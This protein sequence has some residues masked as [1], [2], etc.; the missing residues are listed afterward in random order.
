MKVK[1]QLNQAL[2]DNAITI[3]KKDLYKKIDSL[4]EDLKKENDEL[5]SSLDTKI[6]KTGLLDLSLENIEMSTEGLD[7]HNYKFPSIIKIGNLKT[8]LSMPSKIISGEQ[9]SSNIPFYIPIGANGI[10]V[11]ENQKFKNDIVSFLENNTIKLIS[12]LPCALSRLTIIDKNGSGQNLPNL[13]TLHDKITGGKIL[14]EDSEIERDL[15]DLKHSMSVVTQSITANGFESVEDYNNNTDEIS[16]PYRILAISNFPH[17][18]TK[19]SVESILSIIE[20][21]TKAGIHVF[22]SF[23]NDPKFGMNQPI[24][25]IP[26]SEFTK[27]LNMFEFS[28]KTHEFIRLGLIDKQINLFSTPLINE[29][30]FKQLVNNRY[31]IVLEDIFREDLKDIIRK[32]NVDIDKINIKPVIDIK[33]TIP[34]EF[35]TKD[36]G[37]GVC[38]PFAKSGIENIYL[39]L[40]VNNYGEAESTHHGMI[41]GSTGSGKTVML[42]DMILH[43]SMAY[44]PELL[45]FWLLDYK[46]GTEF[47]VYKDFPYVQIL[48]MESEIE[49]GQQ[50]LEKALTIMSER[51]VIFKELGV[52]NLVGYN[53]KAE[54]L[55]REKLPRILIIIDEFQALFPK[56]PRITAKSNDLI[57]RILRLGR[58]FGINLLLATQTLKGIDLDEN[59]L[60]N[61]PL[62]IALKMD[63]KDSVKL[64]G[65]ENSAPKYLDNPGEGIYNKA[66]GNSTSNVHFQAYLALGDSVDNII[67]DV[68]NHIHN[69]LSKEKVKEINYKRFVYNG[70]EPGNLEKNK[71]I[72]HNIKENGLLTK[73]QLYIGETAGLSKEHT[74]FSFETNFADNLLIIG[75]D[76]E[77]A[78]TTT[79]FINKQLKIQED[80]PKLYFCN[81][82]KK[83]T[84]IVTDSFDSSEIYNNRNAGEAIDEIY[85]EYIKRKKLEEE[86]ILGLQAIY[87]THFFIDSSLIFTDQSRDNKN[88]EKLKEMVKDCSE[89]GIH[90]IIFATNF[91]MLMTADMSRDLDKFKKKIAFKGGNSLKIFGEDGSSGLIE[92]S[93]SNNVAIGSHNN[94]GDAFFKF[95]PYL[96]DYDLNL[97]ELKNIVFDDEEFDDDK[98]TEEPSVSD[99]VI[100]TDEIILEED[101]SKEIIVSDEDEKLEKPSKLLRKNKNTKEEED[102]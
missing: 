75:S 21:G 9:F 61:M 14:S 100:N 79:F 93:R 41:G 89:Y 16:Q 29:S 31:K 72:I 11:F 55:G 80:K 33:K 56:N 70:D 54:D 66:Y 27:H 85:E 50:V 48:S 82:N 78:F 32:L 36:S 28:T 64:F 62:R 68:T 102:V 96:L 67:K 57:D 94:I 95:K 40:G 81:Y 60:S 25:G 51:G 13:L 90:I 43:G 87:F 97:D 52:S 1:K 58:S 84:K 91:N 77:K 15:L 3:V 18:F 5:S 38:M 7:R 34:S 22:M 30:D 92:F 76:I 45:N 20:S 63:E 4:E 101:G 74:F 23:A 44:S 35:W 53:S 39:S 19:K 83:Y 37:M 98:K 46:E 12:S 17:G 59:L 65:D 86:E 42:H 2:Y 47:A 6:S 99:I 69:N 73:G 88:I 8:W 71:T 24:S 26:L 49:F 10:G